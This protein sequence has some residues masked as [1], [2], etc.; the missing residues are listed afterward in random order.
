MAA[1]VEDTAP[2]AVAL[3]SFLRLLLLTDALVDLRAFFSAVGA[4]VFVSFVDSPSALPSV[5]VFF[6]LA[7]AFDD[8][9]VPANECKFEV[10]FGGLAAAGALPLLTAALPDVSLAARFVDLEVKE[11]AAPEGTPVLARIELLFD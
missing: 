5:V 8:E 7:A 4:D 3:S 1:E 2:F 11:E 10:D 6:L 9:F